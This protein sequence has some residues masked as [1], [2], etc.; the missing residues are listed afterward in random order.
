MWRSLKNL[1]TWNGDKGR[2]QSDFKVQVYMWALKQELIGR[3]WDE[4]FSFGADGPF[5]FS[6]HLSGTIE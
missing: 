1:L 2:R 5:M 4:Y 6:K 3:R